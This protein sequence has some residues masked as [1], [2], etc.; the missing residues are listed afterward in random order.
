MPFIWS[1]ANPHDSSW[2]PPPHKKKKRKKKLENL[3]GVSLFKLE[4]RQLTV[5]LISKQCM[6]GISSRESCFVSLHLCQHKSLLV[7]I[8]AVS[9]YPIHYILFSLSTTP[10][11]LLFWKAV[12]YCYLLTAS[13]DTR[14]TEPKNS[15]G[16]SS[17]HRHTFWVMVCWKRW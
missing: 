17:K 3:H 11:L 15:K 2:Y 6:L 7:S 10:Q 5:E 12:W 1:E 16:F 4:E 14:T 8:S 13:F 9:I